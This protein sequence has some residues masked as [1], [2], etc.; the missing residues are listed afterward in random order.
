M[1]GLFFCKG[2][3]RNFQDATKSDTEKFGRW[4]RGMLSRG[5]YLAPSQYEAGFTGLC[6]TEA[7]IDATLEAA[8]DVM[9][10]L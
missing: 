10:Q 2:P 9:K 7:D 1:F 5:V 8:R 3:V 4:H 6:H